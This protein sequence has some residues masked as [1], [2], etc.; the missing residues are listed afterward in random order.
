M[1]R[2]EKGEGFDD[3]E[4]AEIYMDCFK[5]TNIKPFSLDNEIKVWLKIEELVAH[6][7]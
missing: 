2:W 5:A 3:P 1:K 6:S 4:D 7:L